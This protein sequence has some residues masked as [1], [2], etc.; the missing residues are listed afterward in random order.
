MVNFLI[1]FKILNLIYFN[2]FLLQVFNYFMRNI[3]YVSYIL[4]IMLF[5]I[6]KTY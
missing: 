1:I 3:I 4:Y 2:N 5:F 6:S